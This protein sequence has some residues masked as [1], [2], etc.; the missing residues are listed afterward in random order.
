M[1]ERALK[2]LHK[3][4]EGA[5]SKMVIESEAFVLSK[6]TLDDKSSDREDS[7]STVS[8]TR[9]T[10]DFVPLCKPVVKQSLGI[11]LEGMAEL[12]NIRHME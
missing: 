2:T 11:G 9:T 8:L 4:A 12:F 10:T 7:I 6:H 5:E 3:S 1:A